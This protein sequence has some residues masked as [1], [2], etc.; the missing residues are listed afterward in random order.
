MTNLLPPVAVHR[1][2]RQLVV[3]VLTVGFTASPV[4]AQS[5]RSD[6]I[7][8]FEV[9]YE[10]GN[11]YISAGTARLRL[12]N[13]GE[14]WYYSLIT[15]PK[16]VFKLAG[17]GFI[18][19][20]STFKLVDSVQVDSSQAESSQADSG[21]AG[22]KNEIQI[23]PQDYSYRQDDER[24]RAVDARY[25]WEEETL[26]HLYRGTEETVA[27]ED[28]PVLDRLTVTLLI[29]NSLRHGFTS[30][31]LPIF[32]NGGIKQVAFINE[33][34]EILAIPL[35]EIETL[36]VVNENAKGGSRKTITWFAPALDY[37]PVKIEHWKRDELVARL[38][39]LSVDNRV[40]SIEFGE[41]T[42]EVPTE[43]G[44]AGTSETGKAGN[45][46]N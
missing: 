39:L 27:L 43:N 9:V 25:D 26:T 44:E 6:D 22:Q 41:D 28:P 5:I 23:Q 36:R 20:Q 4:M 12:M 34:V 1:L 2:L 31:E 33:G 35:G 17:K 40:T 16:G 8:P 21:Q 14:L 18:S 11:N 24:R 42:A 15:E 32:D 38:S 29:M 7:A 3:G 45:E 19:E 37:L 30:A 10:I 46:A 13:E